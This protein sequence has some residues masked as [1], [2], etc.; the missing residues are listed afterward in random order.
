MNMKAEI[1]RGQTVVAEATRPLEFPLRASARSP[2]R[3]LTRYLNREVRENEEA[4][5][6]GGFSATCGCGSSI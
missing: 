5:M 2:A 4:M 6:T 3:T 1:L